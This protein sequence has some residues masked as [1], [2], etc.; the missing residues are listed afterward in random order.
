[1]KWWSR[2]E[3]R[4]QEARIRAKDRLVTLPAVRHARA[5]P[6]SSF[7]KTVPDLMLPI[8]SCGTGHSEARDWW[9]LQHAGHNGRLCSTLLPIGRTLSTDY[10][11]L[12]V[13]S[14]SWPCGAY[15]HE[16]MIIEAAA[17]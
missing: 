7:M 14:V 2:S 11:P 6:D 9:G 4:H 1:M 3:E 15:T 10:Q 13:V 16:S 12:Y 17:D 5:T 8:H